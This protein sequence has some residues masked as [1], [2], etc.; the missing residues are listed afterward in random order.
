MYILNKKSNILVHLKSTI[1]FLTKMF[2]ILH[3]KKYCIYLLY[4]SVCYIP[5]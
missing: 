4:Q 5:I 1:Y 2:Y 3:Q